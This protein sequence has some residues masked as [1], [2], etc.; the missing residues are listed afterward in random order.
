VV[1]AFEIISEDQRKAID[2]AVDAGGPPPETRGQ[3]PKP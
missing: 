2:R 3:N 1:R